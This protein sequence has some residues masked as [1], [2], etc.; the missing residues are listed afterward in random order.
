MQEKIRNSKDTFLESRVTGSSD[1]DVFPP[2]LSRNQG[3]Y[4][5]FFKTAEGQSRVLLTEMDDVLKSGTPHI[6]VLLFT[7]LWNC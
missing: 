2:P 3:D 1:A 5:L 6:T 4:I 7:V